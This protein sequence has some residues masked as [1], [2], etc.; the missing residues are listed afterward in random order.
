[1]GSYNCSQIHNLQVSCTFI[2]GVCV[3]SVESSHCLRQGLT[4]ICPMTCSL[5]GMWKLLVP[6]AESLELILRC[7]LTGAA[8]AYPFITTELP[9]CEYDI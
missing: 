3:H 9:E 4:G 7:L 5:L 6:C 8:L 1:M 2:A